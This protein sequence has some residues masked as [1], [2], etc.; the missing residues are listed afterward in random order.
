MDDE[1]VERLDSEAEEEEVL[2]QELMSVVC[3]LGLMVLIR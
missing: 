1:L 2:K 3:S